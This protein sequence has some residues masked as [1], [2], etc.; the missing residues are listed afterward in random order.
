[1]LAA[2]ILTKLCSCVKISS[3]L[4][5]PSQRLLPPAPTPTPSPL[6][7]PMPVSSTPGQRLRPGDPLLDQS[8]Y[9]GGLN[10]IDANTTDLKIAI[11]D[12][13]M[14]TELQTL[15]DYP[16]FQAL[17]QQY[18]AAVLQEARQVIQ[19]AE[20]GELRSDVPMPNN[21]RRVLWRYL[22]FRTYGRLI[23]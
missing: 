12:L 16:R 14:P 21:T 5:H 11:G 2:P 6:N 18:P 15:A 8:I 13:P 10:G 23:L 4:P 19:V 22:S 1:M 9:L 17:I 3:S 7:A 20:A